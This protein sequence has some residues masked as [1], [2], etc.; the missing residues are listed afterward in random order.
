M[1]MTVEKLLKKNNGLLRASAARKGGVDNK[2]L[3]KLTDSGELERVGRGIYLDPNHMNDEYALAQYRCTKG[4]FSHDTALYFLEL[5]DRTPLILTMTIPSGYNTR[6]LKDKDKYKF[7]YCKSSLHDMGVTTVET[8]FGN[9]VKCYNKERTICDCI[10]KKDQ[11]DSDIVLSAVKQYV[12]ESG[13]NYSL[14]LKYAEELKIRNT[15]KQY[16]EVLI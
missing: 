2:V 3:Q 5:S 14:L 9:I 15:V 16:L 6:L 13:N 1:N 12:S 10:K 4:I 11:L 8:P 7:F